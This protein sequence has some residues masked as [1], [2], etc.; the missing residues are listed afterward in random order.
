MVQA[1]HFLDVVER[2]KRPAHRPED[3][4]DHFYS[5]GFVAV[6]GPSCR[7]VKPFGERFGNV[8]QQGRNT[9]PEFVRVPGEIVNHLKGVEERVLVAESVNLLD[10]C[11]SGHFRKNIAENF[12]VVE[13]SETS[14]G[15]GAQ[16]YFK[17]LLTDSLP[18]YYTDPFMHGLHGFSECRIGSKSKLR[19]KTRGAHHAQGIIGKGLFGFERRSQYPALKIPDAVVVI[20]QRSPFVAVEA[21]C[22]G[23]DGEIAS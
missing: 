17:E 18:R 12:G 23:V 21:Y 1:Y 7:R 2:F 20:G 15:L 4:S 16:H 3:F 10:A 9:Q 14:G 5:D 11:H 8:V 6:K 13:H 22:K 19:N